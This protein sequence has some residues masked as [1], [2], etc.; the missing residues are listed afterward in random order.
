MGNFVELKKTSLGDGAKANHLAYLGDAEVGERSNI[1]A[2]VITCNYDG[3]GKHKT[4]IG[5]ECFVGTDSHLI[6]PVRLGKGAYVAT[7]TTVSKDV[8]ADALANSRGRQE[9]KAGYASRLRKQLE[10]R[11]KR[12]AERAAKKDG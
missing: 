11:A 12:A 2:G 7:G 1:G 10:S 5:E 9:N 3:F 8:P 4:R 6:A